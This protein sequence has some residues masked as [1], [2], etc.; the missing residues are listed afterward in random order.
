MNQ[1]TKL[2]YDVDEL[3][4][5]IGFPVNTVKKMCSTEP[6]KLPPMLNLPIK[7]RLWAIK[8]VEAWIDAMRPASSQQALEQ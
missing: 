7:R 2:T 6:E 3:A 8:D 1:V 5:A 4:A